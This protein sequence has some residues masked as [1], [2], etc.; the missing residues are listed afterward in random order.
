LEIGVDQIKA[1]R[2]LTGAGIMDCKK[3]LQEAEGDVSKAQ[4][5]LRTKGVA[6][7]ADTV[8]REVREGLVESY[9]HSG[10][11]MGAL[12]EINCETDFVSRLPEFKEL[13]HQLAM[14]VVAMVPQYVDRS[15][16]PAEDARNPEE[17]CLLLQPYIKDDSRVIQDLVT[18][19]SARVGEHIRVR[20]FTRF[21]LG[22]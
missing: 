3:A 9:I 22:E 15:Q 2:D 7:A 20:R 12:I 10:S 8:G 18:D 11:R 6:K 14:Q 13:A 17:V 5:I 4:Q 16:M 1:L 21:A 19:L